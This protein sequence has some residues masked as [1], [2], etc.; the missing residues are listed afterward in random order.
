MAKED[1][2]LDLLKAGKDRK[3]ICNILSLSNRQLKYIIE[4]FNLNEIYKKFILDSV[5]EL[6][7]NGLD[8][9]E[10]ANALN[11]STRK[12]KEII[13]VNNLY[14]LRKEIILSKWV[15][16]SENF[17]P[18]IYPEG[19]VRYYINDFG[20]IWDDENDF[21]IF[22][23][24]NKKGYHQSTIFNNNGKSTTH[25]THRLVGYNFVDDGKFKCRSKG[26][27]D[28]VKDLTIN[29]KFGNKD[30]NFYKNLEWMTFSDNASHAHATGLCKQK[31]EDNHQ[32]ILTEKQV[33]EIIKL[34]SEGY[35]FWKIARMF[36][37]SP[38]VISD[39][40]RNK[41]WKHISREIK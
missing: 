14:D 23:C 3:E 37:C 8:R 36:K 40:A 4:K 11:L 30:D 29:H 22:G 21:P 38:S 2:I 41:K 39:I 17:L 27:L 15:I 28:H 32:S 24:I 13:Y 34:I 16:K 10:I 12:V 18:M 25:K 5:K 35:R 6:Y 19:I 1:L 31:G 20:Q 33:V 7:L 26:F 9:N